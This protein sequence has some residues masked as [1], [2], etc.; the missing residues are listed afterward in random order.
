[1]LTIINEQNKKE[2]ITFGS[3]KPGTLFY[4]KNASDPDQFWIKV[5]PMYIGEGH[6]RNV[7]LQLFGDYIVIT[8]LS[9]S[10]V[11]V[12]EGELHV[13]DVTKNEA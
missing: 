3:L 10:E 2:E 7:A 6:M 12:V 5:S 9:S 8:A 11:V 1:M 4:F 13:K